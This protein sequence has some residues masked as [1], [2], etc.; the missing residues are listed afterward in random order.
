MFP[1]PPSSLF[2]V[3]FVVAV[4]LAG[5]VW[6]AADHRG[7]A[8]CERDTSLATYRAQE[9]ALQHALAQIER[10][11]EISAELAKTQ[12]KLRSTEREYLTYANSITGVC[13]PDFRVLVEYASG[14]KADMPEAAS[15]PANPATPETPADPA[16]EQAITR[17][18]AANV[19]INYARLDACVAGYN[20]LIDWHGANE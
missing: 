7:Y 13:S 20:A 12:Q 17:A 9:E 3:G 2:I 15:T 11:N 5:G 18:T 4:S 6:M 1:L 14:A 16:L 10:G 19:A 8:R